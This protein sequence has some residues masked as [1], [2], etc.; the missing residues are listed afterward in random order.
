MPDVQQVISMRERQRQKERRGGGGALGL[1]CALLLSM[2]V[3]LSGVTLGLVYTDLSRDLPSLAA[4]PALLDPPQGELLQPTRLYDRSG[5][6]VLLTLENPGAAEREFPNLDTTQS[7]FLPPVLITA[8]L[9]SADPDFWQHSGFTSTGLRQGLHPTLAQQLVSDLLLWDEPPGLRRSLRER[10]LAAQITA[11]YGREQVLTWY[12]NSA[13]YGRLAYGAD[14]ASRVYFDKPVSQLTLGEAVLLA[15]V[16]R[17]PALNPLDAPQAALENRTALLHTMLAQGVISLQQYEQA[18]QEKPAFRPP[19]GSEEELAP[20]F[21][22]LVLEQ[23]GQSVNLARLERG[24]LRVITS[25]DYDLQLQADCAARAQL[26]RLAGAPAETLTAD[27]QDCMA[28]RLLPTLPQKEGAGKGE[29]GANVVI[30]KPSSGEVLAMVGQQTPGLDPAHLPGHP[31]GTLINPFIALTAFTRGLSPSTLLWDIPDEGNNDPTVDYQGPVRLRT[32]L[33]NDYLIPL[34]QLLTQVGSQN[35]LE[36]ARQFGLDLQAPDQAG[37]Q[38][39]SENSEIGLLDASRAY[40]VLANQGVLAGRELPAVPGSNELAA[41][42]AVTVLGLE[43]YQGEEW[44]APG[45]EFGQ[46]STFRRPLINPDLAYLVTHV[47]SD[48]P[49]RWPSLGHP[50]PLEIGRP[51]AAKIGATPGEQHAWTIGYTPQILV[52]VWIGDPALTS[53]QSLSAEQAAA[54]WHAI[55]QYAAR[56]LPAEDWTVPPGIS[57]VQVCNPSGLLPT[58]DCPD[59]VNEVFLFGTEPSQTDTLYRKFQVNR[60]TGRLATVFTPP[61]LIDESVFLILPPQA[62]E[63]ARLAGLPTPPDEYDVILAP[64]QAS[65]EVAISEP[66][67]LAFVKGKLDI[68]GSAAGEDFSYY[69]IQVGKGLNP[70]EWLQIGENVTTPVEQ[71]KLGEWEL[72]D[73]DGLYSLQLQVV[74]QN[75]RVD[76]VLVQVTIDN[77]SPQI[78]IL[79]PVEGEVAT[80]RGGQ[81]ILLADASDNLGVQSVAFYIDG[82]LL[83]QRTQSPYAIPWKSES[84]QHTLRV[85]A[86]DNAGN[87]TEAQ[88]EFSVK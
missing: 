79:S 40:G 60:E 84:G 35:A 71:G 65:P 58:S 75:Q 38:Q 69:R 59:V 61:E 14:A 27:G 66:A 63:W 16:A 87:E 23:L 80:P 8:T 83:D 22:G 67:M 85:V 34:K 10:L 19:L 11:R 64:E 29:L 49:A 13:N 1:G 42:E 57:Q 73:L 43:D 44:P 54:L 26:T 68:I 81:H 72:Q 76:S 28:A 41:S 5:Q 86:V 3:A 4:L 78:A 88:G 52:G 55:M 31:P 33:V 39:I 53:Q 21:A 6:R 37:P 36:T 9:A 12:L 17:S 51:V 47:L 20:A 48:E 7:N 62:E 82:K 77:Q 15:A 30:L 74:R 25:L 46:G 50:N 45:V 70:Q 2:V 32:A 24:G 56:D 18:N